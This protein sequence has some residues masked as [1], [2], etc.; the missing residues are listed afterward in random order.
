MATQ[1]DPVVSRFAI[2]Q[3]PSR[4]RCLM[5][6]KLAVA[7][8]V[9]LLAGAVRADSSPPDGVDYPSDVTVTFAGLVPAPLGAN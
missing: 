6:V 2:L 1:F 8:A 3:E 9:L 7:F 4:R 5:K